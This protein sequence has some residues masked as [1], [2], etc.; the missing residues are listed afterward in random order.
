MKVAA[1]MGKMGERARVWRGFQKEGEGERPAGRLG[2]LAMLAQL[3]AGEEALPPLLPNRR[4]SRRGE[5][6]VR[7]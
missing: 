5:G 4:A 7:G 1:A 2:C 6:G 3:A